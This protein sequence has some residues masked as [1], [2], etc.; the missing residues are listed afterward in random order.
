MI[1]APV[2]LYL[3]LEDGQIADL[4]VVARTALAFS[5]AIKDLAFQLDPS[6]EVRVELVSGTQGSLSL[7]A[8]IKSIRKTVSERPIA[9]MVAVSALTWFGNYSADEIADELRDARVEI[10][11]EQL[12]EIARRTATEIEARRARTHAAEI[13]RELS[14]DPAIKGAGASMRPAKTPKHIVPR[15]EFPD[16]ARDDFALRP[17][18]LEVPKRRVRARRQTVIIISPVLLRGDRRW[19]L[20]SYEGE[21]GASMRDHR[22]LDDILSGRRILPTVEGVQLDATVETVD[23]WTGQAW[24]PDE[25]S[26]LQVF[27]IILPGVQTELALSAPDKRPKRK[28]KKPRA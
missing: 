4:E 24:L 1:S 22:F 16:R 18:E 9:A 15:E 25:H 19:K 26:I 13:Y 3:E 6:A 14:Q 20:R 27:D 21:F 2:S 12:D 11:D 7:N 23:V 28:H 8:L 5:A 10:T 17:A